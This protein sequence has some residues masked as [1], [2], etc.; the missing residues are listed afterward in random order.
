MS[1]TL[2][3]PAVDNPDLN[4]APY[5]TV[6]SVVPDLSLPPPS[7]LPPEEAIDEAL[8]ASTDK[9]KPL[10]RN[11]YHTEP[12]EV[13]LNFLLNPISFFFDHCYL[14]SSKNI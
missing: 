10:P 12:P 13:F 11:R 6:P 8:K 4:D 3:E 1:Q 2:P 5:S 9:K 14:S 7:T